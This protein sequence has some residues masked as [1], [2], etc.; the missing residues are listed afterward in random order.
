MISNDS[1]HIIYEEVVILILVI[2]HLPNYKVIYYYLW[3]D[4]DLLTMYHLLIEECLGIIGHHLQEIDEE[5][6]DFPLVIIVE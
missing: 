6:M 1:H 3:L 2:F 4:L 5:H